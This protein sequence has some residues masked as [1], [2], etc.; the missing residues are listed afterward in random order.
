MI[1]V[2]VILREMVVTHCFP[3][4][5]GISSKVAVTPSTLRIRNG[6][7]A[8]IFC[9]V[10]HSAPKAVI[11]WRKKGENETI[12]AGALFTF[13]PNGALQIR[14]I[15]FEEQGQYECIAESTFTQ[16]K[17]ISTNA[18]SIAVIGG[19][20]YTK[21][22]GWTGNNFLTFQCFQFLVFPKN[23][24]GGVKVIISISSV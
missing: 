19:M 4:D 22:L 3:H 5:T 13:T 11:S 6:D 10:K 7:T 2:F 9:S 20:F 8:R 18:A 16:E 23:S 14:N 17:H 24:E 12:T 15:R 1:N 21:Y